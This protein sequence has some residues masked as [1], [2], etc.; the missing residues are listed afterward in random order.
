MGFQLPASTGD[1]RISETSTTT[2]TVWYKTYPHPGPMEKTGL[3]FFFQ[4]QQWCYKKAMKWEPLN[5]PGQGGFRQ[6]QWNGKGEEFFFGLGILFG[7]FNSTGCWPTFRH[8]FDKC[9]CWVI[10]FNRIPMGPMGCFSL[11]KTPALKMPFSRWKRQS[12]LGPGPMI[13]EG[14]KSWWEEM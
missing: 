9:F 5:M 1:R 6:W 13:F 3:P 4:A 14:M 2:S 10:F 7:E 12:F 11:W 8:L